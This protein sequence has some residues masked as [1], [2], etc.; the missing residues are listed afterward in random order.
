MEGAK[1]HLE[2][3]IPKGVTARI[4]PQP[5]GDW[6]EVGDGKHAW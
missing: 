5:N 4:Q 3:E 2:V 6:V 1:R